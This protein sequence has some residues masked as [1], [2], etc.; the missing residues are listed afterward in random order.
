ML[1]LICLVMLFVNPAFLSP[2]NAGAVAEQSAVPAVLAVGLTFVILMG[3]IDLSLEGIMAAA[4]MSTALLV[5]N[6]HSGMNLG[7]WAI[8]VGCAV[9]AVLG[10]VAGTTVALLRVP[11]FIVTIGTWQIGLGIAQLL[12]G[13]TPPRVTDES[14]RGLADS[15]AAGLPGIVWIALL[16]VALGLVLQH[17]TRFGRYAYVIGGSEETALLS[18]VPVRRYRAAS[19]VLA[20]ATAGL[21]AVM[22]T[23]RSG[24]GNVGIATG[25]LF[26]TIAGV[27]IGGTFL[28]GGRGGVLH[29]LVGVIVMVAIGNAMVLAGISS[30]VQQ[31]VQ[32]VIVVAA[33]SITLWRARERMRVIK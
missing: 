18:G 13:E 8:A 17:Y 2:G 9:G 3:G 12:F 14:F 32:G 19:F 1:A 10:L 29:S 6:D 24:V 22:A 5:A 25:L 16:V 31:A 30:Y 7:L 26:T 15:K 20:G 23:A 11:S 21:A 33:A 27:V 4:S 28:T